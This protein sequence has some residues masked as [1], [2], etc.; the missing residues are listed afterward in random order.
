MTIDT[1]VTDLDDTLLNEEGKIS[2]Y[3][4][5]V[6]RRCMQRGIRVIPASGRMMS[7]MKPLVTQLQ[8]GLPYISGNGSELVNADHTI[9][10]SLVLD[11]QISKEICAFLTDQGFYV[12]YYK[13]DYFYYAQECKASKL[14][15]KSTGMYGK[16]VGDLL[17]Y[18][19]FPVPKIL[20]VSDPSEVTRVLPLIR[21]HFGDRANFTVS[22]PFFIEAQPPGATKGD[23]LIRLAKLMKFDIANVIAFGDSLNDMSMLTVAG[24]SV[25]MGNARDDVKEA[26]DY[27]CLTNAQDGLAKFIQEHIL[28]KDAEE[29]KM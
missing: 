29:D 2:D 5:D 15:K 7:S 9:M 14:Y 24:H 25:A 18:L 4:M 20:S 11:V 13:D 3:T 12:Q 10:D 22:K 28:S 16:A 19:T 26:T 8:T 27:I 6:L 21:E 17:S 1:I 23:A